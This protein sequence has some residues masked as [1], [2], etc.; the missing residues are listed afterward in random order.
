MTC[1]T[2]NGKLEAEALYCGYCGR[3]T[4]VRRE[5][6]NGTIVDGTYRID[7]P[8]A[9]GGFG[10]IYRATH[11][12]SG[13]AVALKVLH[14]DVATDAAI[15]ARFERESKALA[16]LKSPHTIVTYAR[17]E[18]R[19]GTMYIA[20]ELLRGESLEARLRRGPLPW[21]Q[22]LRVARAVCE[23]LGEAH[24]LGIVHRDLKPA[25]IFLVGEEAF[26]KVL[27]FG[28]AKVLP[29]SDV[30]G[31][32]LTLVGEAVGTLEYMAPEQLVGAPCDART[33]IYALG[34]VA[35]EMV[36]GQ[37]PFPEAS[38]AP[39]MVMA[40]Y[41]QQPAVPSTIR[42]GLPGTVDAVLLHCLARDPESRYQNV[43]ELAI[44]IDRALATRTPVPSAGS[45]ACGGGLQVFEA[46]MTMPLVALP[47]IERDRMPVFD[48]DVRG[49]AIDVE[50]ARV[51]TRWWIVVLVVAAIVAI[52]WA[53]S[54]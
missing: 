54:P 36:T 41:L 28:V 15:A 9:T 40:L 10:T 50:P 1:T 30:D 35:Y 2:C 46:A 12:P 32:Q 22:A 31:D 52:A 3:R 53:A 18:A 29:W 25:N 16:R 39:M 49:T 13:T 5:S 34:V 4:R 14:A 6:A 26:V 17:G 44:A 21:R 23:S 33:D 7:E 47:D 27:D 42:A 37:R 19:D 38:N 24:A 43:D 11:L 20:M 8:L 51:R 48:I 45:Q